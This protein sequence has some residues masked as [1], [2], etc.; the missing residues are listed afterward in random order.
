MSVILMSFLLSFDLTIVIV[1]YKEIS[2][3]FCA[4]I[5]KII[6]YI[7]IYHDS[8]PFYKSQVSFDSCSKCVLLITFGSIQI[9]RFSLGV[10]LPKR[11]ETKVSNR[12]L[13]EGRGI[14]LPF[15]PLP[16]RGNSSFLCGVC[17][18]FWIE[19]RCM[20]LIKSVAIQGFLSR[21][22]QK[23]FQQNIDFSLNL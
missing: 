2:C 18:F 15:C 9:H 10:A 5:C 4:V 8:S 7:Y 17:S 3:V 12:K 11:S 21:L 23:V 22:R 1:D 13:E 6:C 14:I 20:Q 19:L 16:N